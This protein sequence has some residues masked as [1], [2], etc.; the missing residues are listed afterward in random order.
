MWT[1]DLLGA[2]D[3]GGPQVAVGVELVEDERGRVRPPDARADVAAEVAGADRAGRGI[4]GQA[5]E[6][7]HG[8]VQVRRPDDLD[9]AAHVLV[10]V[11]RHEPKQDADQ[12]VHDRRTIVRVADARASGDHEAVYAVAVHGLDDVARALRDLPVGRVLGRAERA[13]HGVGPGHGTLDR[14]GVLDVALD[15]LE[16][17]VLHV[18]PRRRAGERLHPVATV[19][20]LAYQLPSGAARRAEDGDGRGGRRSGRAVH[21]VSPSPRLCCPL[22]GA[23]ATA[24]SIPN[25]RIELRIDTSRARLAPRHARP[26][27]TRYRRSVSSAGSTSSSSLRTRVRVRYAFSTPA[28]SPRA[29]CARISSRW[30]RSSRTSQ[31]T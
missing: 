18:D 14:G 9:R 20:G 8:P 4:V 10:D 24:R 6:A 26:D 28:A 11:A 31:A 25:L 30:A 16:P 17:I 23:T 3:G 7:H 5:G 1:R 13:D 21:E 12:P 15:D 2:D 27:R 22:P 29:P 19:D